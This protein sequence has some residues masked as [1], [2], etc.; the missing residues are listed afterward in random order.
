M[1]KTK[2]FQRYERDHIT[3]EMLHKT[4]Q[5]FSNNYG[6]WSKEATRILGP[7]A[8]QGKCFETVYIASTLNRA[9]TRSKKR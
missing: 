8:R 9:K 6:V 3:D 2:V 1:M 4:A 5:L 7:F